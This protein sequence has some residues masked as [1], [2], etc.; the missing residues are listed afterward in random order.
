MV[1]KKLD[2]KDK[3]PFENTKFTINLYPQY[4]S[5]SWPPKWPDPLPFR[6]TGIHIS[7][8]QGERD[9]VKDNRPLGAFTLK[10]IPKSHRC[11]VPINHLKIIPAIH[12]IS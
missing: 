8:Y 5:L 10:G 4:F 6:Q 3:N 12:D 2:G 1:Q 7:V 11:I 9:L